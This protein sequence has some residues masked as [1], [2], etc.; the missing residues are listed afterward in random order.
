[1]KKYS[2]LPN[3]L[4]HIGKIAKMF[5]IPISTLHFWEK[6]GLITPKHNNDNNYS[7]YDIGDAFAEL[8]DIIFYRNIDIPIKDINKI[9]R[10]PANE[11]K[12]ILEK[13]K[14]N[15]LEK[16]ESYKQKLFTLE[17]KILYIDEVM[18]SGINFQEKEL[19]FTKVV[20]I[21]PLNNL[22]LIQKYLT[23]LNRFVIIGNIDEQGCVEELNG[24]AVEND[25]PQDS[26]FDYDTK[27]KYLM[28]HCRLKFVNTIQINISEFINRLKELGYTTKQYIC[29]FLINICDEDGVQYDYYRIWFKVK[30]SNN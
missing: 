2:N 16:I 12:D 10:L 5:D 20:E 4:L 9:K 7:E 15:I 8:G 29:Q 13:N 27:S 18:A 19:P 28:T 6:Q 14:I 26:I 24:I 3:R 22:D 25:Y 1:M 17:K 23:D 11:L 30:D 21:D